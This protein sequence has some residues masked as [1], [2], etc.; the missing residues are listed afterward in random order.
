[1]EKKIFAR[2]CPFKVKDQI[3]NGRKESK[4]KVRKRGYF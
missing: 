1:M 2:D 4:E 3:Y